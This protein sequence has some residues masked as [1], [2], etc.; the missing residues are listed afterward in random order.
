MNN[1]LYRLLG[2]ASIRENSYATQAK[3]M[4]VLKRIANM[5]WAK[6][7]GLKLGNIKEK[8][9]LYVVDQLSHHKSA[10][11][12]LSHFRWILEKIGKPHLLPRDNVSLGIEKRIVVSNINKSWIGKA[13]ILSKIGEVSKLDE[14]VGYVLGLCLFFG[15]RL[16]EAA[17]FRPDQNIHEG[18]IDV[19]LGT[20][21]SRPR[22]VAIKDKEQIEF[23]RLLRE[24][25]RPGRSIVPP[26]CSFVEFRN[27]FYHRIRKSGITRNHGLSVHGLRHT[28]ACLRY[29][30]LTG[31]KAP[32][33]RDKVLKENLINKDKDTAAR[34]QIAH[35][36]GHGRIS[37]TSAYVGGRK[38]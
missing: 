18:H 34:R 37:V 13:D 16:K 29:E 26:D 14:T 28:Y 33:V 7:H 31:G 5:L 9:C 11:T 36:L 21:G 23:L 27:K 35:E 30:E 3:R 1:L 15:L 6:F 22:R 2:I 24:K 20:K 38:R 8:H 32:V 12:E 10:K 19:I 4:Q 25:I 17:L